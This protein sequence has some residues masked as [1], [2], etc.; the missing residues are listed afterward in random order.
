[1]E[2]IDQSD[3][4]RSDP[5]EPSE[6]RDAPP[7]PSSSATAALDVDLRARPI[8]VAILA[9]RARRLAF[10]SALVVGAGGLVLRTLLVASQ[11]PSSAPAAWQIVTGAWLVAC[12]GYIGASPIAR[13]ILAATRRR[14]ADDDWLAASLVVPAVGLSLLLPLSLH[15]PF[16]LLLGGARGFE[17]WAGMS[18]FIVGHA[19]VVLAVLTARRAL[20]LVREDTPRSPGSI[21]LITVI[22]AAIPFGVFYAIPPILVAVTGVPILA[23][24]HVMESIVARERVLLSD[25]PR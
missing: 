19:H 10:G 2:G 14:R 15:M 13:R 8:D 16:A 23:L 5:S 17:A 20:A 12:L 24:L 7:P 18:V 22:A 25:L 21:Y 11:G 3:P 1:M 9:D 6:A 4:D